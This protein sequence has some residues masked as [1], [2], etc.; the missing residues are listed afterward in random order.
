MDNEVENIQL[1]TKT[2]CGYW[3]GAWAGVVILT[4]ILS[5]SSI[6]AAPFFP[7]GL[8]GLLGNEE[9]GIIG[10]MTGA[11]VLGWMLYITLTTYMV[12]AEKRGAFF[13]TYTVFCILLALN[14]AGCQR[15]TSVASG[16][17]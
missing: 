2:K 15:L 1:S 8:L 5:P 4:L 10:F 13:R 14:V 6:A 11:W 17:H 9:D 7:A 12:R 16:I 3:F